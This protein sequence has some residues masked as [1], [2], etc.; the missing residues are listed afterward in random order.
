M[1][2]KTFYTIAAII[3]I[4]MAVYFTMQMNGSAQ[5]GC[6]YDFFVWCGFASIADCP[7]GVDFATIYW[8]CCDGYLCGAIWRVTCENQ[9]GLPKIDYVSCDGVDPTCPYS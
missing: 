7:H 9:F 6:H 3:F 1:K 5:N 8:S 2:Q 4:M